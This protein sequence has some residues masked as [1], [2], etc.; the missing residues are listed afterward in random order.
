MRKLKWILLAVLIV[1]VILYFLPAFVMEIS[2]L[3]PAQIEPKPVN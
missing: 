1:L 2:P 3:E